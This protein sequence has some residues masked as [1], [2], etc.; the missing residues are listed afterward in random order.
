MVK[1][2]EAIIRPEKLLEVKAALERLGY[3]GMTVTEVKGHGTQRGVVQ[4]WQGQE[5]WIEFLPKIWFLVVVSDED[6]EAVVA[7]ICDSAATGEEGDGKIFVS[8]LRDVVRVRTG[9]RGAAALSGGTPVT[10]P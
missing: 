7:A 3:G 2:I 6:A 8:D 4:E 10:P 1:R 5:F 9:E